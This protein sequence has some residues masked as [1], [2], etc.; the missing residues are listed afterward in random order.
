[1]CVDFTNLNKAFPKDSFPL[2]HIN[3]IM[4]STAEHPFISFMD[5]YS[6]Y[7]QIR[8]SS[9]DEEK[10]A[11][12]TNQGLYCYKAMPFGLKNAGATYQC[13]V[14]QMF[15]QQISWNIEV[16]VDDLLVKSKEPKQHLMDLREA[17]LVLWQ[18]QM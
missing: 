7:N 17:F 1:M 16:Y 10:I 18:Y 13:L 6:K 11:F 15:K 8:M 12:V 3:L 14:N 2:P 4:D 9:Y 5:A